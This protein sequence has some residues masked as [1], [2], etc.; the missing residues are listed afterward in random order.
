MKIS[1][2]KII[3]LILIAIIFSA[4]ILSC[5]GS[6]ESVDDLKNTAAKNN[7]GGEEDDG[8]T[9]EGT[10]V[11]DAGNSIG[12][13]PD[14]DLPAKNFE[15]YNFRILSRSE[16]ANLHWWNNDICAVE[17]NIG[18]PINDAL[19]ERTR[20]VEEAYNITITNIPDNSVGSKAAKSIKA[21]SDDYDLIVIGLR[22]G[23]ETLSNSGYL[24]DLNHVPYVDLTKPWWDQKAVEQ[25]SINNKLFATSCDLTIRDKDATIILMFSKTLLQANELE[26][27]YQLVL[28]GKWTLD[29]MFGMMKVAAKDLNG[30][31][32]MGLDDQYGLLSQYRHSQY[33]FNAAGE[34]ISKLNSEGT[35]EITL[36]SERSAAVCDKIKEIQG[37]KKITI[38]AE[39]AS[40]KFTDIWDGFQ[41]PLFAEDRALFYHA[42]MNRVTLLRNMETDFGI[43]PPPKFD[44]NQSNYYVS[45]DAWCMSAVSVPITVEDKEKIGL[46][47]ETLAYESRYILLPVYYDINLKTKFA[48]DEQSREMIDIILNNRLYD[49]GD[50][51]QSWGSV[52]SFF[53]G[54]SQNKGDSLAAYWE[55]NGSKMETAMQKTVSKLNDF[56]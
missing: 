4:L 26:D 31:G 27:P 1:K 21:G 55:K 29:K 13:R 24:L 3:A 45:V 54:L 52:T 35:P 50:V 18:D 6:G 47:L 14:Y 8:K 40:G 53:E 56:D 10:K 28:S 9:D 20:K 34:Y 43:I 51:Y 32:E 2:I 25:L 23:Q 37:D 46:I 42:G 38:Y 44:E 19:Y 30:D 41:V 33:M 15:K 36:Y 7:D 17:E 16:A 12:A 11:E 49:L 48:R 5:A 39:Q 22:D